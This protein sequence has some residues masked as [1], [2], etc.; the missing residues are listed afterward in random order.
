M[1]N[2]TVFGRVDQNCTFVHVRSNQAHENESMPDN[3]SG[4]DAPRSAEGRIDS[5]LFGI[6]LKCQWNSRSLVNKLNLFQSFF[7]LSNYH[8][9]AIVETW[10]SSSVLDKEVLVPVKIDFPEVVVFFNR[11]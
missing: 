9:Y 2:G 10:C 6:P 3:H 7:S 1:V 8:V 5:Q 11:P 4:I